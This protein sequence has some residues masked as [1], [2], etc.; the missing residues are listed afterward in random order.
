M[1]DLMVAVAWVCGTC[2]YWLRTVHGSRNN[3]YRVSWD[4][5]SRPMDAEY[6]WHCTCKH[7]AKKLQYSGGE[8]K[9]IKAVKHECCHWNIE[10]EPCDEPPNGKCPKCGAKAQ[11]IQVG[12]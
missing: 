7:F 6:G 2:F 5:N 3:I 9:H 1:P 12:V 4:R 11:A 10:L 8:C